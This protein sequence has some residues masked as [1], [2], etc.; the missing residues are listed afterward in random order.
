MVNRK[1][2]KIHRLLNIHML[3]EGLKP[4]E[5]ELLL[6]AFD[7]MFELL[8]EADHTVFYDSLGD[9]GGVFGKYGWRHRIG[10]IK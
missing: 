1:G 6:E 2:L 10:W 5:A 8:D 7:K 3:T 4:S 9:Y